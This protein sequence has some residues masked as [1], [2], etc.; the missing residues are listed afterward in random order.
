MTTYMD[1]T[2]SPKR[3]R[4]IDRKV[5]GSKLHL[6]SLSIVSVGH[7]PNR[8]LYRREARFQ[9]F[10][11]VY[12]DGGSG[13]YRAGSGENQAVR[14]GS[15]FFFYPGEVFDYGP[16]PGGYWDEYYFTIEGPRIGE[17]LSTWLPE[18]GSVIQ[19]GTD[20]TRHSRISRIFLHMESG[21]ASQVDR[22][23]LLLESLLYDLMH[24][25]S[26][27][28][29]RDHAGHAAKVMDELSEAAIGPFDARKLCERHHISL[30]T[31]RRLVAKHT[32]YPLNEYVHRLKIA[33]AKN[34]LLNTDQPVK[35]IAAALG[36]TDVFYFSRLFKKYV[37]VSP[38]LFRTT[39]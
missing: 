8:T 21:A 9:H 28:P 22:A 25:A 6:K 17:W 4:I 33:E 12:I 18:P 29:Q 37:G 39:V 2:I 32:G 23:S 36:Y 7:L 11:V 3:I 34:I 35:S 10:A 38:L 16:E 1:Y 27:E 26:R 13:T 19:V 14:E 30:S 20:D 31:L 15:L 24:P 5:D